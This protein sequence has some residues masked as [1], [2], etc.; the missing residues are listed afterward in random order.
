MKLTLFYPCHKK[1]KNN[2]KKNNP[3]QISQLLQT[4]FWPK[5]KR[6]L[7]RNSRTDSNCYGDIC[8][9]NICPCNIC[10]YEEYFSCYWPD[11][12]ETLKL[13]AWEHL[14]QIPTVTVK[15]LL[16]KFWPTYKSRFQK[17]FTSIF[18]ARSFYLE[19]LQPKF[20]WT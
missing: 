8:P 11:F 7:L 14:E 20:V 10:P 12:D 5:F 13:A 6:R 19:I 1:N 18:R 17:K 4:R 3:H 15:F 9:G 2:K 16:T